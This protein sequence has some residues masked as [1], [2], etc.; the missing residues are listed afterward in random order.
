MTPLF[1]R[2]AIR[3]AC[4]A[5]AGL[6]LLAAGAAAQQTTAA[7]SAADLQARLFQLADDSLMGRE[8]GARGDWV[9]QEM[10]AAEFRRL[11][12]QPAG[13]GGTYFQTVPLVLRVV[14]PAAT[15]SAGRT[16]FALWRDFIPVSGARGLAAGPTSKFRDAAVIFGGTLG[17]TAH[18]ITPSAG[19]GRVVVLAAPRDPSG[20]RSPYFWRAAGLTRFPKAAALAIVVLDIFPAHY[21]ESYRAGAVMAGP[22][23]DAQ[24]VPVAMLVT[25]QSASV[26][27][28]RTE[29]LARPG[30]RGRY[31]TGSPGA[32][33][34]PVPFAARNVVAILPGADAALRGEF[35]SMS[36]HNDHVGFSRR[37]VDHDS[38][39]V[40]NF[41]KADAAP[42]AALDSVRRL[43]APRLDSIYNGADDDG[44]GTVSLLE[45]AESLSTAG[46]RPKR[47]LL[48][49]S[50]TA[51]EIGLVGSAWFT[52][53]P[54][55]PRDSIVAEI[56]LDMVGRGRPE[57]VKGGNPGYLELVG[58]RRLSKEFG[59]ITDSVAA[60]QRPA[61]V[62]NYE[63][64]APGH[65]DNDYCR[66][67]HFSY[68]RYGIPSVNMSRGDHPDY[69]EVSDEPQYIDYEALARVARFAAD[70]AL[71]VADL[72]H[73]LVVD[74]PRPDPNAPC[75][76]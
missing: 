38:L 49:I 28:G 67:D 50:H 44:S 54:T 8:A 10:I 55:V 40:A 59:L 26:L 13:E 15:L 12:L 7:I 29:S 72:D 74:H 47:S 71:T 66:A 69:H 34:R 56:D 17:D 18:M 36:A 4:T 41:A 75:K 1:G 23:P 37:P 57:D 63:F 32:G 27:L 14:D 42:Q 52:D 2:S 22:P 65:P 19:A 53:H 16:N 9:A 35:V 3:S 68:A 43:R 6:A 73:R 62:I 11:G 30:D 58:S 33:L 31:A 5:L 61:F 24:L 21:L 64:D 48:F 20:A 60:A 45:I 76:Q 46:V 51:E 39:R 70:L 25:E